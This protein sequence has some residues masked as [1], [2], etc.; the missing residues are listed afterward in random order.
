[1]RSQLT[2]QKRGH[3]A[4]LHHPGGRSEGNRH[5]SWTCSLDDQPRTASYG[6]VVSMT[7]LGGATVNVGVNGAAFGIND[8]TVMTIAELLS[9]ANARARNRAL[10]NANGAGTL[11]AA[12]IAL[13]NQAYSY[14]PLVLVLIFRGFRGCVNCRSRWS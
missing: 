11:S 5:G 6:F 12:E 4:Q 10:W 14:F 8:S 7:G 13:R 3:I 2:V 1:M 9:R